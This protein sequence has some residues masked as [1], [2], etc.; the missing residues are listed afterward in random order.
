VA[1]LLTSGE[2]FTGPWC[3]RF[4]YTRTFLPRTRCIRSPWRS[5]VLAAL[6]FAYFHRR[7]V[8]RGAVGYI[9]GMRAIRQVLAAVGRQRTARAA[10]P[11]LQ[12]IGPEAMEPYLLRF[13]YATPCNWA[14]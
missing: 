9:R 6:V 3:C 11:E 8:S 2:A 10:I 14:V 13:S 12:R 7:E 1:M 5:A 4:R